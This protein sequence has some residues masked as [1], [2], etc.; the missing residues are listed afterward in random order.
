MEERGANMQDVRNHLG[1]KSVRWKIEK[2]VLEQIGHVIW[3]GKDRMTK[4]MVLGWYEKSE[5][6]E[7]MRGRKK[8]TVL[9]WKRLMKDAGLGLDRYGKT[10][11]RKGWKRMTAARMKHLYESECQNGHEYVNG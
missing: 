4:V 9:I 8:K 2:P 6:C 10:G 1:V 3:M 7:K 5:G 11:E